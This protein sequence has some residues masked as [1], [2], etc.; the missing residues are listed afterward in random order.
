[1]AAEGHHGPRSHDGT[2][3][4]HP[5]AVAELLHERGFDQEVVAAALLHDVVEDTATEVGEIRERFGPQ[6]ARL[7]AEMTEDEGIERYEERKAEHRARIR[8]D[9]CVAAIYAADK[10]ANARELKDDP[11]AVPDPQ[12]AH[13]L[14]TLRTL[15]RTHPGLPF[16]DELEG[17]LTELVRA[18]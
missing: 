4:D 11:G 9:P 10:L 15:R 2:D 8:G 14:E 1:M 7:V 5:V 18:R 13:Y 17:E 3:V 6:V 16:L 12:V